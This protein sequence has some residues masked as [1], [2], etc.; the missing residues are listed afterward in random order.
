MAAGFLQV[1]ANAQSAVTAKL[2][3][4]ARG[5]AFAGLVPAATAAIVFIWTVEAYWAAIGFPAGSIAV[6]GSSLAVAFALTTLSIGRMVRIALD[7]EPPPRFPRGFAVTNGDLRVALAVLLLFLLGGLTAS[8]WHGIDLL[9]AAAFIAPGSEI[10]AAPVD[11]LLRAGVL[12]GMFY[13]A[14]R[15]AILIPA[16]ASDD[17]IG[18]GAAWA[19]TEGHASVLFIVCVAVPAAVGLGFIAPALIAVG[20]LP[21]P[22][23]DAFGRIEA[24]VSAM[25]HALPIVG[26]LLF[27]GVLAAWTFAAAGLAC[28]WTALKESG[29]ARRPASV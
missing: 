14:G 12:L 3:T 4:H 17:G 8:L 29:L 25:R 28:A 20:A 6:V 2:R 7:L 19:A 22:G 9:L 21:W 23:A 26:P 11:A 15:L 18:L 10:I 1:L 24:M 13:I 16:L 27:L 5:F